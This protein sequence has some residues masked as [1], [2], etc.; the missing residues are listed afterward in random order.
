MAKGA[1]S[2]L[3]EGGSHRACMLYSFRACPFLSSTGR[4]ND[5]RKHLVSAERSITKLST[6]PRTWLVGATSVDRITAASAAK[7]LIASN[8]QGLKPDPVASAIGGDLPDVVVYLASV[9]RKALPGRNVTC[10]CGSNRKWKSCHQ[11]DRAMLEAELA[12]GTRTDPGRVQPGAY[13]P[14]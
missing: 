9:P 6:P 2:Y 1:I 5:Q 11:D 14:S 4:H 7:Y 3:D 13:D 12:K 8:T 10:P